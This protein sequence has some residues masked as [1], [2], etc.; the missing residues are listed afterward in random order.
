MQE[1]YGS[2]FLCSHLKAAASGT[3]Q[4]RSKGTFLVRSEGMEECND[5]VGETAGVASGGMF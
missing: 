1:L 5:R 2:L 4:K 3:S